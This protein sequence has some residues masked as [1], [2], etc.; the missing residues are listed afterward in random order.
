MTVTSCDCFTVSRL[1]AATSLH[2]PPFTPLLRHIIDK[3]TDC[4]CL[5][6]SKPWELM[7]PWD[8]G[9]Q[10][11]RDPGTLGPWEQMLGHQFL[12]ARSYLARLDLTQ[13]N[14]D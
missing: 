7:G 2:Y 14:L 6:G 11:P 9:T 10:G 5:N 4:D 1:V 3:T 12:D 8:P 13:V